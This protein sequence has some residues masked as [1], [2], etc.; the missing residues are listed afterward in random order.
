M[1]PDWA[2][3]GWLVT[4]GLRVQPCI[5]TSYLYRAGDGVVDSGAESTMRCWTVGMT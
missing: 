3:D 4:G 5:T 2:T 1:V